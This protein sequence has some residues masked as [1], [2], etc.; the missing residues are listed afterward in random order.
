MKTELVFLGARIGIASRTRRRIL[1]A[2]I[3]AGFGALVT[4]WFLVYENSA[5]G[6][7]AG[8]KSAFGLLLLIPFA[9]LERF[10][11]G[12]S[13]KGGLVPAFEGGDER[14]LHRRDHAYYAA[15][16]WWDL[17]LIPAMLAVGLKNN[18]FYPAWHPALRVFIDRLP[19]G[20]LFAAGILY[21]TLPQAILLWTEPDM[22]E[23]SE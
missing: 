15:Y 9:L 11:G 13:H 16:K 12:R 10:L 7:L 1:V 14:Q 19:Y 20:L 3:Y 4:A 23:V 21:Y 17:T 2:L 18:P 8:G 22:E 5:F 6:F